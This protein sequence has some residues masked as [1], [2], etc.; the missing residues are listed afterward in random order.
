[1]HQGGSEV[2]RIFIQVLKAHPV[3]SI[4]IH[5][6]FTHVTHAGFMGP[7]IS[8]GSDINSEI[9]NVRES[10]PHIFISE[11]QHVI[12]VFFF[13]YFL[14]KLWVMSG[15]CTF[16]VLLFDAIKPF[17]N[18]IGG[19]ILAL[20]DFLPRNA[21]WES[22]PVMSFGSTETIE[23]SSFNFEAIVSPFTS[24]EVEGGDKILCVDSEESNGVSIDSLR[25]SGGRNNLPTG[26]LNHHSQI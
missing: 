8:L 24:A 1:L 15:R 18:C 5:T 4:G 19:I 7:N 6:D 21:L 14:R 22:L 23:A 20:L 10:F 17:C 11:G 2:E 25:T 13:V 9:K 3:E 16:G 26:S 12:N